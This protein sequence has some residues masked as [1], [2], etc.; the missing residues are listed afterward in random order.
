MDGREAALA[1][2]D[3]H[4]EIAEPR[5]RIVLGELGPDPAHALHRGDEIGAR[6]RGGQERLGGDA[7]RV[8]AIAAHEAPLDQGHPCAQ[9]GGARRLGRLDMAFR[10][11]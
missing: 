9:P 3:V 10:T 5:G 7:A 4:S 1:E 6:A 11:L 8:Q 2:E